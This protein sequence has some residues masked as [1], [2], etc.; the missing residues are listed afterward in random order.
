AALVRSCTRPRCGS[1]L[2]AGGEAIRVAEAAGLDI[3]Q[4]LQ[5][6]NAG[7][8]RSGV[9]EV[10]CPTWILNGAFDSGFTMKLMRKD[11]R[12]A[13]DMVEKAGVSAPLSAEALR[14]WA[15]SASTLADDEDFNRIV[16]FKEQH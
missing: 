7:S 13:A 10:N 9:T 11:L 1:T 3:G 15:D 4:I 6:V 12:L 16:Q 2:L 8:G 5:G 14:L